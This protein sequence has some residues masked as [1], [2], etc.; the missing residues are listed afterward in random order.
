MKE[1]NAWLA[2]G[3]RKRNSLASTPEYPSHPLQRLINALFRELLDAA[4]ASGNGKN[5]EEAGEEDCKPFTAEQEGAVRGFLEKNEELLRAVARDGGSS[6]SSD[7]AARNLLRRHPL[8]TTAGKPSRLPPKLV[9]T[10]QRA[11]AESVRD[12]EKALQGNVLPGR[13][14]PPAD[15]EE[16]ESEA[17]GNCLLHTFGQ[18]FQGDRNPF[19]EDHLQLRRH[20][21]G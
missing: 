19:F 11:T 4:I 10:L 17:D 21:V 9:K 5:E 14:A 16:G 3:R 1:I 6:L 8:A 2:G 13:M 7:V 18:L 12:F 15:L 20:L